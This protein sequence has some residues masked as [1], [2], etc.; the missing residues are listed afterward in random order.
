MRPEYIK[1]IPK[2]VRK[3]WC[4]GL[5]RPFFVDI[6]HAELEVQREGRL[7]PCPECLGAIKKSGIKLPDTLLEKS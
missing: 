3:P 5:K 6:E 1:C 7:Q 2:E 4:G